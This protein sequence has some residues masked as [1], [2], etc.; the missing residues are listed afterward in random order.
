MSVNS[1]TLT[2][3]IERAGNLLPMPQVVQRALALIRDS[4]SD[5]SELAEVLSLD[6][7]MAGQVLRWANSPFYGLAQPVSTVRQAVVYL[8]QSA[9]ESMILAASAMAFME[10]PA[11]GY[12]LDRG[13]LWKHSV[14]VAA[15]A[16]LAAAK[17]GRQVAEEAYFAGL[18]CDIGKLVFEAL[19]RE[20]DTTAP[21]W[22]GR[23]FA[24]LEECHFGV[25]HA[26]LGAEIARQWNLPAPILEAIAHHHRPALANQEGAI[27][28]AAVHVA[29]VA[30]TMMGVGIGRD[31]LKYHL[32]P[33]AFE[34]LNWTEDDFIELLERVGP[35]VQEVEAYIKPGS[36]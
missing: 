35:L 2:Q 14:G 31:G 3:L 1:A 25:D 9:I 5:M 16:R 13:D 33:A 28:A 17:F 21:D 12:A 6:Q 10:R 24:E 18:L 7:A 34:R 32:D 19:L 23:S 26:T 29:D 8:G 36:F 30:I 11:P 22:Q 20:V 15:G 27:L 4:E